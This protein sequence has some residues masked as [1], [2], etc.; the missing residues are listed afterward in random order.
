MA[1]SLK[2]IRLY[3]AAKLPTRGSLHAAG[4]DLYS[5]EDV[6]ILAGK[7]VVVRTGLSVSI[8][9]GFYGRIA[10]RS[11][12]ALDYGIDVL[13]GVIDGDYRGEILCILINHGDV[14]V[15][16]EA[17]R[18][19]AQL[20]VEAIITPQPEWTTDLD[21]TERGSGRFGSSEKS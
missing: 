5:I 13:A 4:L 7:R 14:L 6:T 3:P 11:G 21:N 20:V 18:R 8:P 10:P 19:I 16:L 12:L 15:E 17:G 2:F 1:N 9:L